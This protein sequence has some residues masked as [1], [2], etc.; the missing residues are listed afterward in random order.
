M[1]VILTIVLRLSG[2]VGSRRTV[3]TL[4]IL[5]VGSL[6]SHISESLW[7]MTFIEMLRYPYLVK[8]LTALPNRSCPSHPSKA[9]NSSTLV[10]MIKVVASDV[11]FQLALPLRMV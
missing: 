11:H 10:P 8:R 4:K 5:L 2:G 1:A 7:E 6:K 9:T 3:L